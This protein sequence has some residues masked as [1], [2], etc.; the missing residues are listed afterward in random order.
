MS[1]EKD[2]CILP[3]DTNK[4][5]KA[6]FKF[7]KKYQDLDIGIDT[8]TRLYLGIASLNYLTLDNYKEREVV[9]NLI[10]GK[11]AEI[12]DSAVII[13]G[14]FEC[15]TSLFTVAY[16]D[17]ENLQNDLLL[18]YKDEYVDY[19]NRLPHICKCDG[20]KYYDILK[21][22]RYDIYK[23]ENDE[24]LEFVLMYGGSFSRNY[25]LKYVEIVRNLIFISNGV[26]P[27]TYTN[28]YFLAGKK[29]LKE[30]V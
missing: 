23:N 30:E 2:S 7:L 3:W 1:L 5:M 22:L 6:T 29:T 25:S 13:E 12:L 19:M 9:F 28:G 4:T 14:K 15:G 21:A 16:S 11:I 18:K 27:V 8:N 17:I 26:V 10:S 20:N 24:N